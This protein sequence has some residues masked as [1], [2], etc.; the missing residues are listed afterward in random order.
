LTFFLGLQVKQKKDGIFI[1]QDKYAASTLIDT[2]KPLVKDPDGKD[3]TVAVKKV[4]DVTR[5]QALVDKKNVVVTEATI[6]DALRLDDAEG[7]ECLPNEEIFAEFARMGYEKPSTK[8]TFYKAFFSSQWKFLIHTILQCMSAKRTSWNEFSSSLASAVI[9]LSSGRKSNFSKKQ[10][11]DISTHTTKYTSSAQ[12][13]KVFANMRRVEN[14]NVGD[15]AEGDV[16]DAHD[17]VPTADEEPSIPSPTPPTPPPQ[18][19]Q[20]IPSTSQV[21]PTPP[22]SP[23]VGTAQRIDTSND[24]VMDDVSNQG[25][26]ISDM[27]A[28]ADVVLE[29]AKEVATDN[30]KDDQ[31][32]NVQVNADIQGRKAESQAKIYK[33]DL[34]HAN[35]VLS[36][37]EEE[38]EP[39]ELQEVVDIVTTAK[40]ITE[41]VTAA[42]TTITAAEVPVPA[43]TTAAVPK[44]TAAPSRRTKGVVIRDPEEY[45]TT[46]STIIHSE[47]KY[48]DTSKGVLVKEPKPL[49]KQAQIKQDEKYARELEAELNKTIDWDEVIDHVNK[50]A[51]EDKPGVVIRDPEEYSTTT[52]T[53]IHSEA[54]YKDTSKGVLVKEPKPLK[55]QAQIKQDE[56][57]ARELE[58]ELNKTIDWDEVI[59][60]VNKK[61]KEDKPNV[62][63]FKMDYF[64]GMTYD[65][66][67]PVFEKHFDLNVSFLQKTKEQIKE[68][69]SR[70]L[71]RINETPAEKEAKRRKLEE[72]VEEL[73]R[74]LQIVPIEDDDRS[75]DSTNTSETTTICSDLL[76]VSVA[77][78]CGGWALFQ[79]CF[80]SVIE[81]SDDHSVIV[82]WERSDAGGVTVEMWRPDGVGVEIADGWCKFVG[83]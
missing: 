40:I 52:S 29:E 66:I 72:E 74:H 3:T 71:K 77:W 80:G 16:S 53:I 38:S 69:E 24:T 35:K 37:Q 18:P 68:E 56:K 54:K 13:Q 26:M 36:M 1:S 43:A 79:S 33:I 78:F 22:Q 11:G 73:K 57:Y 76:M 14:V 20:D 31:D 59:D 44:L 83:I 28:D 15:I 10:V 2:E 25:R 32:T 21:Q 41:V 67:H 19:S 23:Q 39:V 50:K 61:A 45:S 81:R 70:A 7:F 48:K 82:V 30:A 62:A 9:C 75:V 65:D 63:G 27:D 17:A 5:L 60:H 34:D 58:A 6:R 47:A 12:T 42:S 51:K 55:K 64:K 8:L 49:K 46:T 4:N